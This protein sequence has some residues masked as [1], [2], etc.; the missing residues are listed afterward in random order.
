MEPKPQGML[1]I[2]TSCYMSPLGHFG[3][4]AAVLHF[5]WRVNGSRLKVSATSKQKP[6]S[7]FTRLNVLRQLRFVGRAGV[8]A[9]VVGCADGEDAFV[10]ADLQGPFQEAAALIVQKIFVPAAFYEFGDDDHDAPLRVLFGQVQNVLKNG[11][12]DKSVR[13]RQHQ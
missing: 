7:L 12:Y 3:S 6:R 8:F 4:T 2:F 5:R 1:T 11:Q 10:A 13:R 9:E